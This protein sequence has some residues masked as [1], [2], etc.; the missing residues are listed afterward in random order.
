MSVFLRKEIL[1]YAIALRHSF[2]NRQG[3][4]CSSCQKLED[5]RL[6]KGLLRPALSLMIKRSCS[7][8]SQVRAA[9]RYLACLLRS[10]AKALG[11][12]DAIKALLAEPR[13][14]TMEELETIHK[15]KNRKKG[16]NVFNK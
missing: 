4:S 7:H 3:T 14:T 13:F 12:T 9:V 6:E 10:L 8:N 15:D 5:A 2:R 11:Y 16:R 1:L